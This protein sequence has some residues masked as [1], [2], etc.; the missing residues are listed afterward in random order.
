MDCVAGELLIYRI[1][2]CPEVEK[3]LLFQWMREMLQQL[4]QYR[5][6]LKDQSYRYLNPYSVLITEENH[7]LLLDL[8]AE[9]NDFVLKNMQ[10]RAMRN[11]F[12][13]P[14]ASIKE[15]SNLSI[16]L[17]G[18]A[19]TIQFILAGTEVVPSLSRWEEI[20]ISKIID[21][22]LSEDPNIQ[23]EN[24]QQVIKKIPNEKNLSNHKNQ[25]KN[26]GNKNVMKIAMIVAI[27]LII[28]FFGIRTVKSVVF[29]G[30]VKQAQRKI[31]KIEEELMEKEAENTE[32]I[33]EVSIEIEDGLEELA[34]DVTVIEQ[35]LLR[36]TV[37]D[38][39]EVIEQGEVIQRNVLRYLAA[40]YDREEEKHK[41]LQAYRTLCDLE[42]QPEYLETAYVRRISLERELYEYGKDAVLTGQK[43]YGIFP[44]S[45]LVAVEYAKALCECADMEYAEKDTDLQ[46]LIK[47]FPSL[48]EMDFYKQWEKEERK[49]KI[50][51]EDKEENEEKPEESEGLNEVK[52]E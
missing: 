25:R 39:Q 5:K 32:E 37:K 42:E 29:A 2:R 4:E 16:D 21:K 7:I 28:L 13:K 48:K 51:A 52:D 15:S 11:H 14:I 44:E 41:A 26:G 31:Y 3:E 22:C 47:V 20:R 10:T 9:S 43:A 33:E 38:N 30:K 34:K 40:A 50:E 12:M 35:Y 6:Y 17:Y 49:E 19:K 45:E 18:Y 1:K 46:I 8:E 24:I 36:N 23:Y 27:A